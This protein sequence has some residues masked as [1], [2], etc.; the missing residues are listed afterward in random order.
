VTAAREFE[1]DEHVSPTI[2]VALCTYNGERFIAEQVAS[3]LAQ[4]SLPH[5]LVVSDDASTDGTL[6]IV[7][8]VLAKF[9]GENPER[10]VRSRIIRNSTS[11]G[12]VRNFEQAVAATTGELIVLADQDDRWAPDRVARGVAE[13]ERRPNLLLLHADANLIDAEGNPLGDS[14]FDALAI[15]AREKAEIAAGDAFSALLR[16]NLATGATTMFRRPLLADAVPFPPAWVHDEW[17][18]IVAAATGRVDFL[19]EQLIDYRQH[20]GNA[21]GAG[22]IGLSGRLERLR[23]PREARNLGLVERAAALVDRLV[24]LG[25]AVSAERVESARAKLVH[26]RNRLALPAARARRLRPV[27]RELSA[28]GYANY[29]RGVQDV[30]RDLVQPA[31]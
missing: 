17:L 6:A 7:E 19:E 9:A 23:E 29:G 13:F 16:R 27:L 30:L 1:R 8:S 25:D 5:E 11:L 24:Q 18:A 26:E 21:I 28:G 12:V 22:R 20:G 14:L 2:S 10:A 15:T 4:T 31:R 3:I